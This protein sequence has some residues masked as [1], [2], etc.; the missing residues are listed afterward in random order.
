MGALIKHESGIILN[1][2]LNAAR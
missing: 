2:D 1:A